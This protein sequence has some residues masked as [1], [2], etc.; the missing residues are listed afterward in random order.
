MKYSWAVIG[1][2][3][4]ALE[5]AEVLKKNGRT[6]YGIFGRSFEKALSFARRF[7]I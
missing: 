2:G 7:G 3:E 1:Y 4:I 5:M 6:F